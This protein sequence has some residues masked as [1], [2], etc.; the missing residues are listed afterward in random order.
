VTIFEPAVF[1]PPRAIARSAAAGSRVAKNHQ[2]LLS[3]E[4]IHEYFTDVYWQHG[5]RLDA[6]ET[7]TKLQLDATGPNFAYRTVSENFHLID[8]V[9]APVIVARD[10]QARRALAQLSSPDA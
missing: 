6:S 1:K 2:D 10:D 5:R 3:R 7:L 8:N 4:A 9:L